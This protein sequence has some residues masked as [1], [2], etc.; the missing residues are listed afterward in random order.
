RPLKYAQRDGRDESL[1][2]RPGATR[3]RAPPRCAIAGV[4]QRSRRRER[5][6]RR[7]D[8]REDDS[9]SGLVALISGAVVLMNHAEFLAQAEQAFRM[10]DKEVPAGIQAMPELFNQALLF[11]FVEIDHH[12]AAKNDV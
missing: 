12:V 7:R 6:T 8:P 11:G 10:P 9:R 3:V 4:R 5:A 1:P 2:R